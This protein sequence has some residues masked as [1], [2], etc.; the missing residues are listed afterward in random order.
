MP[1]EQVGIKE[2]IHIVLRGSDGKIKDERKA[3]KPINKME[4]RDVPKEKK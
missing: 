2:N 3:K 4:I 1:N